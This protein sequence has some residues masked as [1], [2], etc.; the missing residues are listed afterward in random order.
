[1]IKLPVISK[2]YC[3]DLYGSM[4]ERYCETNEHKVQYFDGKIITPRAM[5]YEARRLKRLINK[6]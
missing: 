6:S 3:Y 2:V 4:V 1:M 5:E